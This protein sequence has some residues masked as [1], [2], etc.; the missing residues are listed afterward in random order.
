MQFVCMV[1]C[2]VTLFSRSFV[3]HS[4]HFKILV[5]CRHS[6]ITTARLANTRC[7][8]IFTF[9]ERKTWNLGDITKEAVREQLVSPRGSGVK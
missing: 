8:T 2:V 3:C 9:L 6:E 5:C 1:G 4:Y 7:W